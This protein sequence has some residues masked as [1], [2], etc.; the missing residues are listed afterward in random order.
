MVSPEVLRATR[1]YCG[2][3]AVSAYS[4]FDEM[5]HAI[6]LLAEHKIKTNIHFLLTGSSIDLAIEWF[7]SPP[8]FLEYINAIIF[9]NYKAVGNS[10]PE[11]ALAKSNPNARQFFEL[12]NLRYPFKIGF[13]SCSISGIAKYMKINPNSLEKCEA[14]RFSMYVSEDMKMYPCSFMAGNFDGIPITD[15]NI[16]NEWVNNELF[17]IMRKKIAQN[18][19]GGCNVQLLCSGG[20]PI[21]PEIN[22]CD[23]KL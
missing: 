11:H 12:A 7:T 13:D 3:V 15:N 22:F 17:R 16:Q 14:A 19:C 23:D 1:L 20:C 8:E 21:F 2:A 10:L 5:R 6:L 4:P 18:Q 9:L